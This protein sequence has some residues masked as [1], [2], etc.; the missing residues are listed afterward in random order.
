M[1]GDVYNCSLPIG[2]LAAGTR[3]TRLCKTREKWL[4]TAIIARKVFS[5]SGSKITV[6]SI[7]AIRRAVR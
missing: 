6:I 4:L 1:I 5:T 2:I 3:Y 7:Y